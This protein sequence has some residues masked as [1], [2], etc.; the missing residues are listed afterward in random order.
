ME[1]SNCF[2]EGI[3]I[4]KS[5]ALPFGAQQPL[6]TKFCS[7]LDSFQG[8]ENGEDIIGGSSE[9]AM[10]LVCMCVQKIPWLNRNELDRGIVTSSLLYDPRDSKNDPPSIMRYDLGV[11]CAL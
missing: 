2:N 5:P 7:S 1:V 4:D 9:S 3:C 10:G 11:P 8:T 6:L